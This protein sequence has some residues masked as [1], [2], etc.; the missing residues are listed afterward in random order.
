[1]INLRSAVIKAPKARF[2]KHRN[3]TK[4]PKFRTKGKT[5]IIKPFS[6]IV[7]HRYIIFDV[8]LLKYLRSKIIQT[9]YVFF[10]QIY[11]YLTQKYSTRSYYKN[12]TYLLNT[13][14]AAPDPTRY[15]KNPKVH[16]KFIVSLSTPTFFAI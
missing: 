5:I 15:P 11:T 10:I 7:K 13:N 9:E 16:R 2:C 6:I 3:A 8:A 4:R 12:D 1:M 14:P